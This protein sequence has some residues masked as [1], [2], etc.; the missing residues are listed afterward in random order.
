MTTQDDVE[1]RLNRV[2]AKCGEH[3]GRHKANGNLC[4]MRDDLQ[5]QRFVGYKENQV[6]EE[7]RE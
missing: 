6:F 4:P 7:W 1:A 5:P 3:Y 2:C